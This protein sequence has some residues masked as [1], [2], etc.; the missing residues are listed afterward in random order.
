KPVAMTSTSMELAG[1]LDKAA[2][3]TSKLILS[4]NI[5]PMT[6]AQAPTEPYAFGGLKVVPKGDKT[7]SQADDL[8]YF[9]EIRNPGVG[10]DQQ[11]KMQAKIDVEGT[12][13][14]GK[15]IKMSAPPSEARATE[16]K[17]MPGHFGIG[18]AIPLATFKPGS[19]TISIK[20]M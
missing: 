18:S 13:T 16:F 19:Y 7:F 2:E 12:D 3:G 17:G 1:T 5:Y 6:E 8:W 20:L 9:I 10:E 14:T 15:K 4:N 11:P